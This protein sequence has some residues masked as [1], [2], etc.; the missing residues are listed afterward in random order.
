MNAQTIAVGRLLSASTARSS[1][2]CRADQDGSPLL[3]SL[4]R[5]PIGQGTE[6]FGLVCE[7]RIADDG[8]VR[9]LVTAP[10][11]QAEVLADQR[12]NR[13]VPVEYDVLHVGYRNGERISHLLPPRPPL[14]L[15]EMF[16]CSADE[17]CA[18]T[19]AG[20]FGYFRHVLRPEAGLP[21]GEIL[22]AHLEQAGKAQRETGA[23]AGWRER[24]VRELIV[25]L[26]D[27]Y[28][29]LMGVLSALADAA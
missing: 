9:Q 23:D 29:T 13:S 7:I 4:V 12:S 21:A 15:D 18:F 3:G 11:V 14:S 27:D 25:L 19:S 26:R 20:R 5:I 24:A 28:A 6:I 22:A 10:D 8:L 16:L 17:I 1:V 2:G